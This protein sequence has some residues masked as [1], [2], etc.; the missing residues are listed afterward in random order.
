MN[1]EAEA[2]LRVSRAYLFASLAQDAGG[3]RADLGARA[4]PSASRRARSVQRR[5]AAPMAHCASA[6]EAADQA[7]PW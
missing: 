1:A 3:A 6:G 4:Y 5:E 2:F 7:E